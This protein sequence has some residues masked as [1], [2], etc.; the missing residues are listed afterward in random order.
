MGG[1]NLGLIVR[2]SKFVLGS[3]VLWNGQVRTTR[4]LDSNFLFAWIPTTDLV[5]VGSAQVSVFTPAPAGGTS[6][7]L[8]FV[9]Q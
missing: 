8:S 3:T 6:A 2:G 5:Q 4:F 9:I 1:P 7:R